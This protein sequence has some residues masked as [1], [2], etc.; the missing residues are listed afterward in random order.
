MTAEA[1]AP[2]LDPC[3][4]CAC[5]KIGLCGKTAL[6]SS[7]GSSSVLEEITAVCSFT[8]SGN[9]GGRRRATGTRGIRFKNEGQIHQMTQTRL[10]PASAKRPT[11]RGGASQTSVFKHLLSAPHT[12]W[13]WRGKVPTVSSEQHHVQLI[14]HVSHWA[15]HKGTPRP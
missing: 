13:A 7:A 3:T 12:P 1:L 15:H 5:R 9:A 10:P 2:I 14:S 11:H 8:R 4:R 6:P